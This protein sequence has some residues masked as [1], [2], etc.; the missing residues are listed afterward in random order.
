MLAAGKAI[1]PFW[2]IYQAHLSSGLATDLL[3]DMRVGSLDPLEPP[4]AVD[5]SDPYAADPNR[6]P[7]LVYHNNKPC[8]AEL[9]PALVMQDYVTPSSLWFIRHHH[10]VPVIDVAKWRLGINGAAVKAIS[11][12]IED[13]RTRFPKTL[14]TSTIQ[15]GGNRRAGLDK[16]EPT[17]GISWGTGAISTARWGGVLLRDVLVHSGLLTAAT[18]RAA[19]VHHVVFKGAD[20]M[21][22]SIPIEKALGEYG[23][24]LLAYEMNGETLPP[25]HGFPL[26]AVVPGHVGVRNVKWVEQVVASAVEAQGPWQRGIAYKGFSPNVKTFDGVDVEAILSMQEMPVQSVIVEPVCELWP[27]GKRKGGSRTMFQPGLRLTE[28]AGDSD[29]GA[30]AV[31]LALERRRCRLLRGGDVTEQQGAAVAGGGS[32]GVLGGAV[33]ISGAGNSGCEVIDEIPMRGWAWSGGGRSIVRVDVSADGGETWHTAELDEG[34]EQ[35]PTRAWAWTFWSASV[36]VTRDM[37]LPGRRVE[38]CCRATDASYN[39]QPERAKPFWNKRGLNNTSW[40]RVI[41]AVDDDDDDNDDEEEEEAAAE[42]DVDLRK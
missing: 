39:V 12:S 37:L 8:N 25:E 35:H 10:P 18:A 27:D 3:R 36:P 11:L 21:E 40:H 29:A 31:Q 14:V 22:A 26:R 2:R 33:G 38:L 13:L 41:V 19:G 17:A 42:E 30:A 4:T 7:G 1:D 32:G 6:H 5:N 20:G 23:D 9:P 28:K 15:C 16:V 24:V 34:S